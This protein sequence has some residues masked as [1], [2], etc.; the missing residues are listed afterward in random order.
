MDGAIR[1]IAFLNGNFLDSFHGD[2]TSF[3]FV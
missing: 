3:T 2:F 1:L